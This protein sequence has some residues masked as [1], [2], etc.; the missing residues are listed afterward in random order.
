MYQTSGDK[1]HEGKLICENF[2]IPTELI[3][4][5]KVTHNLKMDVY[6]DDLNRYQEH[7]KALK[8]KENEIKNLE[9]DIE[10]K[11]IKLDKLKG[12]YIPKDISEL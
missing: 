9:L 6:K 2:H 12:T 8:E 1:E 11:Q 7:L 3:D 4:R 10:K 5:L